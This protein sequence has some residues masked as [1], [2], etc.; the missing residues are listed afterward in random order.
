VIASK[1][2]KSCDTAG[3][4]KRHCDAPAAAADA[5]A[6]RAQTETTRVIRRTAGAHLTPRRGRPEAQR[7]RTDRV[8]RVLGNAA[9]AGL[10]LKPAGTAARC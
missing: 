6:A 4:L 7:T 10:D 3:E 2:G 1:Y 9:R 5:A 8:L